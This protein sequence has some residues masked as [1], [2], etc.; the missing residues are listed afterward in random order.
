MKLCTEIILVSKASI[1]YH[2]FI[3]NAQMDLEC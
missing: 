2:F 3:F 1:M